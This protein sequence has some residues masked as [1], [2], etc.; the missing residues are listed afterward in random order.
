MC[1]I[2]S[3][4]KK[5]VLIREQKAKLR[6]SAKIFL[7]QM[8]H[9]VFLLQSENMRNILYASPIWHIARS[10]LAFTPLIS[11]PD[12]LP[13][14]FQEKYIFCLKRINLHY[15][16]VAISS[17]REMQLDPQGILESPFKQPF[18]LGKIDLIL[19]PGLAFDLNGGRLGRGGG[20]Y[21]R[22][23]S[24]PDCT[25]TSLGVCFSRQVIENVPIEEHD[26]LVDALLTE[27]ELV[28]IQPA[29]NL[30]NRDT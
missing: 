15:E 23:L 12:L 13:I 22:I 3:S 29:S 14:D 20:Q 2:S 27:R 8:S 28:K 4:A 30:R 1:E 7:A 9:S 21:D 17:R 11:E 5:I 26:V 25:G 16:P 24:R 6:T 18:P 10:V 19:V